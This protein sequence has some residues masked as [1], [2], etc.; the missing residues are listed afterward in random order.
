MKVSTY[1]QFIGIFTSSSSDIDELAFRVGGL[2]E[3]F[4]EVNL[5]H[6]SENKFKREELANWRSKVE[7]LHPNIGYS[8]SSFPFR[9]ILNNSINFFKLPGLFQIWNL[10]ILGLIG[11][12]P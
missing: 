4:E 6:A 9:K 2:R 11:S 1:M 7:V 8:F 12:P 3:L 10:S 5:L